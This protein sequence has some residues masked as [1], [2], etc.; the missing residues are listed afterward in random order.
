MLVVQFKTVSYYTTIAVTLFLSLSFSLLSSTLHS[1]TRMSIRVWRR[2]LQREKENYTSSRIGMRKKVAV[3][4]QRQWCLECSHWKRK[5]YSK[6]KKIRQIYQVCGSVFIVS[7]YVS[8]CSLSLWLTLLP[9]ME[10]LTHRK[11]RH[12]TSYKYFSL[13]NFNIDRYNYKLV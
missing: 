13:F 1:I 6:Q 3:V 5:G 7:M 2:Q 8:I 12:L 4:R 11:G 10:E 9:H